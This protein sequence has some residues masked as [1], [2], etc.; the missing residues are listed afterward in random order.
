MAWTTEQQQAISHRNS[1]LIVSAAAG[2][3]KTSVLV[4]RLIQL[5]SDP[6]QRIYADRMIVV[7]FTNDAAAEMKQRLQAALEKRIA[8]EP[9]NRWLRQQQLILPAAKISTINAFCFDLIREYAGDGEITSSFRVMDET[10]Q[11]ILCREAMDEVL[12]RWYAERPEAMQQLWNAFCSGTDKA[13]EEILMELKTFLGSIPFPAQ[14]KRQVLKSVAVPYQESSYYCDFLSLLQTDAVRIAD[15][16]EQAYQLAETL[17]DGENNVAD[18]IGLDF[19]TMHALL[20]ALQKKIVSAEQVLKIIQNHE[21]LRKGKRYPSKKKTVSSVEQFEQVKEQR[22]A[23]KEEMDMLF[24]KIKKILPYCTEDLQAHQELLPLLFSLT[25]EVEQTL[26]EKKMECNALSFEDGE[27]L[28]LQLLAKEQDGALL[29]SPLAYTLSEYYQIIMIDEY[30]DANNKQDI[31]FKLLSHACRKDENGTLLYGDNVFLVGDVKQS[32]YQFRLANPKN[33]IQCVQEAE[34]EKQHSTMPMMQC[35]KLNQNFRSSEQVLQF[36]NLIFSEIMGEGSSEIIYDKSEW[37]YAGSTSY[38]ALSAEQQGTQIAFLQES[39]TVE[40]QV[41]WIA[42]TIQE[43]LQSGYPVAERDGTIRP[44]HAGD[45]CILLRKGKPCQKYAKALE[46]LQIPVK[47]VEE[48]GYLR[49][50]EITILLNMLRILDNPLL[51]IPLTAVMASPMFQF[52]MDEIATLRLLDR[53]QPLYLVLSAIANAAGSPATSELLEAARQ[54][55]ESFQEK[56]CSFWNTVQVLRT[57]STVLSLEDLIREIYDTTDFLSVM[58]LY[59]D[60][61]KK[62]ANLN[63]LIQYARQYETQGQAAF[64]GGV[65]GFLRYIDSLLENERDLEQ[66]NPSNGA[67]RAVFIKTMHRSKGLEFPFVFLAEL[68]TKFSTQDSRKKLHVSDS[69]RMGLYLYDAENY[70]KYST[71]PYLVLLQ[72]KQKQLVQEEM[73]LLYV[74]MTRAKQKLFLPLTV[75][76]PSKNWM[77]QLC[78]SDFS[79][80]AIRSHTVQSVQN[81]AQWIWYGLFRKQDAAFIQEFPEQQRMQVGVANFADLHIQYTQVTEEILEEELPLQISSLPQPDA[82]LRAEI[83]TALQFHYDTTASKQLSLMSVSNLSHNREQT[84][85][86][87]EMNWSRPRFL[88]QNQLTAT[89]RG[90]ATHAFLQ[91]VSFAEAEK[92]PEA[93]LQTLIRNGY[94]TKQQADSIRLSDLQRFF[95]S[96]LYQ[97]IRRSPMVLREK[98]FLVQFDLLQQQMQGEEWESLK[99]QYNSD[100]M[101]KGIIDLA[102]WEQNGFVLV[103]Y[104]TD[105]TR[106]MKILADRYRT[107]LHLYRLALE[108]ITGETVRQCCLFSTYTGNVVL[109]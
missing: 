20:H 76:K 34:W 27:R 30:Q 78:H 35:I 104:K 88:Q 9:E 80:S 87:T 38:N 63:L 50:R 95:Q 65:T 81:M 5:L 21:D 102:F 75:S 77:E 39:D 47:K 103:D 90:T 33:F 85:P 64:T 69:G 60:G 3:G 56:C 108:G 13:L 86:E 40:M 51:E 32:I 79:N 96:E 23:Y 16:V 24:Q 1:S 66:A 19:D 101:V 99:Q 31:I 45:F 98:K 43:M 97:R 83:E 4:E 107:Q 26:W 109:L 73:R 11:E 58:Q 36:V 25:E 105:V 2:S 53:N 57:D 62:R 52:S 10:E 6:E 7:T 67:D 82:A 14:W 17:Y 55:P 84:K 72:E 89:E 46:A 18:W 41:A 22:K 100:S 91:Y 37:L 59:Q 93:A 68:D 44:C 74:A 42:H 106:N 94:L 49:A 92:S 71:L 28:V 48:Q 54:L 29:Q 12:N 15:A 61:E 8:S 70:E